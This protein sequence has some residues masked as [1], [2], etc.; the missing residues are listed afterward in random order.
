[1]ALVGGGACCGP[2]A[3]NLY[4]LR[5]PGGPF[6]LRGIVRMRERGVLVPDD[7]LEQAR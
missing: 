1:M 4:I 5:D 7:V 3:T 2:F 6:G